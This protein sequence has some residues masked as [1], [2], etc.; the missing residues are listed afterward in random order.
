MLFSSWYLFANSAESLKKCFLR[1]SFVYQ[2][3]VVLTL[4]AQL[5]KFQAGGF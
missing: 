2:P 5:A 1:T 4:S 3:K